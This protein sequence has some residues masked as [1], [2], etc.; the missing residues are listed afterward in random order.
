MYAFELQNRQEFFY[1]PF[2]RII[3]ITL[4]HKAKEVV[5]DIAEKLGNALK[6]DLG[7]FVI[8]PA[9]PVVGRIRNQYLMELFVKLPLDL[10]KIERYKQVIKNHFNLLQTEQRFKSVVMIA[11]VDAQ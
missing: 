10:K 2:S 9:A 3:E 5:D 8:G 4:K 1:P 6:K 7:D 11:D